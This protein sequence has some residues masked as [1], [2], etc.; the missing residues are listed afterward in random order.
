M[1][2]NGEYLVQSHYNKTLINGEKQISPLTNGIVIEQGDETNEN[3]GSIVASNQLED[4]NVNSGSYGDLHLGR[5][6][7]Y[8]TNEEWISFTQYR[9]SDRV[10]ITNDDKTVKIYECK[11]PSL[12][13][14][15][16]SSIFTT[17]FKSSFPKLIT[18]N[19]SN[20]IAI[21]LL[22]C[23]LNMLEELAKTYPKNIK[24]GG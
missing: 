9:V 10:Q 14:N 1:N 5:N 15:T 6:L 17:L 24:I 22:E 16:F 12:F 18:V 2:P 19:N 13:I 21:K 20:E 11:F 23:M 8:N 4:L 7:D 3:T